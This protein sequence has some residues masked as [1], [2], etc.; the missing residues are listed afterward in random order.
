MNPLKQGMETDMGFSEESFLPKMH[1]HE[2]I[3]D[4]TRL[5]LFD[6]MSDQYSL[7]GLEGQGRIEKLLQSGKD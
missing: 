4:K 5:G 7:K 3:L 2:K 6:K 1:N